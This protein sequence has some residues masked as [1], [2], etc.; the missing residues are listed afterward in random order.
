[1]N[2]NGAWSVVLVVPH[3]TLLLAQA[4]KFISRDRNFPGGD[5][6]A[7]DATAQHTASRLLQEETGLLSKP[8]D[9]QILDT[10][11]GERGQPVYVY[12]VTR[13]KGRLR[14]SGKGKVFWTKKYT[15]LM[16]TTSTFAAHNTRIIQKLMEIQPA[17]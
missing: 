6:D 16:A 7:D 1:M 15:A 17:A 4:R 9:F 2:T 11:T 14:A 12:L 13:F 8:E 10:W 5:G 3:G